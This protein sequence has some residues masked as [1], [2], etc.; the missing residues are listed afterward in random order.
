MA[1][2]HPLSAEQLAAGLSLHLDGVT[3]EVVDA[4]GRAGVR[5]ILLRGPAVGRWLYHDDGGR[6]YVDVD[7]LIDERTAAAA[8]SC[9]SELGFSDVSAAGVLPGDRPSHA[10]TWSRGDRATVD[11]HTTIAGVRVPRDEAWAILARE[12]DSIAV[13]GS[14]VEILVEPA[15]ALMLALHAA[16]HGARSARSL[17]D[18]ERAIERLPDATWEAADLLAVCLNATDSFAVGLRL[19]ATGEVVAG[20]LALSAMPAVDVA[21]RAS[22]P[23]PMALGFEWLAQTPGWRGKVALASR[24]TVPSPE[25]MRAWS[26]LAQRGRIGLGLAYVWRPIWLSLHAGPAFLAWRRARRSVV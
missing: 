5:S 9:L 18:L 1:A 25:F 22:T 14:E 12:T 19:L 16:Q 10:R 13:A 3:A 15:R 23:P 26:P 6:S 8:A 21:L 4:F 24:K 11:L 20:R 17:R 7:L 2:E